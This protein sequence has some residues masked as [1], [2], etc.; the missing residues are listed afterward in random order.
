MQRTDLVARRASTHAR[1]R[2]R[3]FGAREP[4]QR[5]AR[6]AYPK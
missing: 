5:A 4:I 1:R 6:R 2:S 3:W